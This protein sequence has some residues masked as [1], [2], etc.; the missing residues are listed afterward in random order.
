MNRQDIRTVPPTFSIASAL[1]GTLFGFVAGYIIANQQHLQQPLSRQ[2]TAET[3]QAAAAP[4]PTPTSGGAPALVDERELQ[5]YRDI[6]ARDPKN[7]AA[8][9]RL[10]DL[11][12]DAQRYAEAIPHYQQ[13]FALDPKNVN[14]STD[15][16]TALWYSGRADEALAQYAKS[17]AIDARHGQTLFNIGI[18]KLEGKHDARGAIE[19]WE[20]LLATNPNSSNAAKARELL[21][22]ARAR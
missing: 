12:Y 18:V 7:T 19:S 9:T 17:L 14:V 15:L 8:A 13:A 11:L 2:G 22:K 20:A 10:G 6:L 16:G 1:A 21:E 5:T 3:V 4:L